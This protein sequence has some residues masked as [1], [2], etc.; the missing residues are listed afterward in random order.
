VAFVST[1]PYREAPKW[2]VWAALWVA[3]TG[4][5]G[6]VFTYGVAHWRELPAGERPPSSATIIPVALL[7]VGGLVGVRVPSLVGHD[8]GWRA[9]ATVSVCLIGSAPAAATAFAIRRAARSATWPD[10]RSH[11]AQV[12][13]LIERR[14]SLRALLAAVGSLVALTTL[15]LGEASQIQRDYVTAGRIPAAVAET[16]ETIVIAGGAS[17]LVIG[18]IYGFAAG[19][20]LRRGR[21]LCAEVFDVAQAPDAA[22]LLERAENRQ[23]LEALTGSDT[24]PFADLQAGLVVLAP[25]IASAASAFLPR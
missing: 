13:W 18:S 17:S 20:L 22:T 2:P 11:G 15:A 5:A 12:A 8:Y 19:A 16:P 10:G 9:S 25:L 24:G 4:A 1:S 14:R 21:A 3:L 7:V 23:K 6:A